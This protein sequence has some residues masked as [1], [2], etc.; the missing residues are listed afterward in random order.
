[1]KLLSIREAD[2][3]VEMVLRD[4]K[5]WIDERNR[6][7]ADL[8]IEA[9]RLQTRLNSVRRAL[10][11][12]SVRGPIER[13]ETITASVIAFVEEH[14]GCTVGDIRKGTGNATTC[15][16]LAVRGKLRRERIDGQWRYFPMTLLHQCDPPEGKAK[17]R[18]KSPSGNY[19]TG[20]R[21]TTS[22]YQRKRWSEVRIMDDRPEWL[23]CIVRL[24]HEQTEGQP[25]RAMTLWCGREPEIFGWYFQS[26]DHGLLSV[27]TK[28]LQPCH[29]CVRAARDAC[30]RYLAA[31]VRSAEHVEK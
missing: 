25:A 4:A 27:D 12:L 13:P 2:A 3:R 10:S 1:M 8:T 26:V 20:A 29:D 16:V 7:V 24:F 14:P 31:L 9:E 21:S 23:M 6:I 28:R 11:L 15:S 18:R 17:T 19:P 30:D 22:P 5:A